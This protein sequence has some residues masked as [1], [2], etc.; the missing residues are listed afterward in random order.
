[1]NKIVY[2][3]SIALVF[4]ACNKGASSQAGE[5]GDAAV[6]GSESVTYMVDAA[7]SEMKWKGS[8][9]SGTHYGKVNIKE[10]KLMLDGNT[11]TAGSFVIDM[12]SITTED[13][14]MPD[15]KKA[16]LSGHLS[17]EDFFDVGNHPT[18]SFEVTSAT[19]SELTGNLTIKGIS[20]SITFPYFW[21][22]DN[23]KATATSSFSIDRTDW[24][25]KYGSGKFFDNLGD[26]MISDNID[27]AIMLSANAS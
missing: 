16:D 9:V 3:L 11:I 20:K 17:N 21:Q 4:G 18:A 2:V 5:S 10:G 8:K 13:E 14:G 6:A 22:A 23:G 7:T 27:F 12:S 24:G 25:I 1:M 26:K 19:E 15:N